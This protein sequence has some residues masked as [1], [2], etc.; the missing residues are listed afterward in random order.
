M[1]TGRI[2]QVAAFGRTGQA[3]AS[4]RR[5]RMRRHRAEARRERVHKGTAQKN[6]KNE[7][8]AGTG[9]HGGAAHGRTTTPGGT[10]AR[11][12]DETFH[13][14]APAIRR[15]PNE[16]R[17]GKTLRQRWGLPQ[18][19][20]SRQQAQAASAA[21]GQR[22]RPGPDWLAALRYACTSCRNTSSPSP[23]EPEARGTWAARRPQ[24]SRSAANH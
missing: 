12:L 7:T 11:S 24:S 17:S 4:H 1:T 16:D 2:N 13:Q 6:V 8:R 14:R 3:E 23:A 10:K 5:H 15:H 21:Q 19:R 22:G 18:E 20:L 9:R